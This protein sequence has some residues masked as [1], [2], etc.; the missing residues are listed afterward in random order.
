MRKRV[1]AV[2]LC[3]ML[4]V[5]ALPSVALATHNPKPRPF[6]TITVV[7]F[8]FDTGH[9]VFTQVLPEAAEHG[10]KISNANVNENTDSDCTIL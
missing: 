6:D 8:D 2:L 5:G 9:G 7:C 3:A 10:S 1:L 4:L